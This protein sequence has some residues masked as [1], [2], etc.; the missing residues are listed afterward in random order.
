[1][2]ALP[3]GM[4]GAWTRESITLG[5][6]EPIEPQAVRYLQAS[7]AYADLRTSLA[8]DPA[9]DISF[10]GTCSWDEPWAEWSR[11][12][13]LEP[14]GGADRGEITWRDGGG[15]DERGVWS[16]PDGDVD[17]LEVWVPMPAG[18]GPVLA[19]R[20]EQPLARLVQ[21]GEHALVLLDDRATG[22]EYR[23]RYDRF[24]QGAW[25]PLE[26][27]GEAS[28]LPTPPTEL[29]SAGDTL[30]LGGITWTVDEAVASLALLSGAAR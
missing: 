13:D 9:E 16:S 18:E 25:R 8:G 19:L 14:T 20:C 26:S 3:P 24:V 17:Y 7:S 4:L 23:G 11:E 15:M 22:G 29:P 27:I 21:V 30:E 12:L 10:A 1:V 28:G 2:T 6:G 5:D